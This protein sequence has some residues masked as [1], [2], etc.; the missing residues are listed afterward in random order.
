MFKTIINSRSRG[1]SLNMFYLSTQYTKLQHDEL[2]TVLQKFID[3]CFNKREINY[4]FLNYCAAK[5]VDEKINSQ[6]FVSKQDLKDAVKYIIS[7]FFFYYLYVY[8]TFSGI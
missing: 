6:V 3:F 2:L 4:I 1:K 7:D 5:W 8:F